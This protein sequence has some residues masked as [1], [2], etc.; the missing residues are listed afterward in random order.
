M[1]DNAQDMSSHVQSPVGENPQQTQERLY[2]E[3][4]VNDIVGKKK[5]HAYQKGK[6][7]AMAEL[8][9][10]Q[11]PQAQPMDSMP[12]QS[13]HPD[14]VRQMIADEHA[15]TMYQL[16]VKQIH[17]DFN[18]KV[19]AASSKYPDFQETVSSLVSSGHSVP[20]ELMMLANSVD[21]TG[22]VI[23]DLAKNPAKV[24]ALLNLTQRQ[25]TA[26]L[27]IKEMQGLSSSIK[28]NEAAQNMKNAP[29]PLSQL[30]SSYT[31]TDNGSYSVRDF[32]KMDWMRQK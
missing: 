30:K 26:H 18:H 3:S 29:E 23:Y 8:Q 14:Q 2:K 27:A 31:G 15:K 13:M 1:L 20:L 7:D 11:Q 24:G 12:T 17:D 19:M 16:Q 5:Q 32:K 22:D 6:A 4:E 28:Q 9:N 10:Q 21:N 25:D